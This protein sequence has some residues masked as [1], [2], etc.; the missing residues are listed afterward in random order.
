MRKRL[1]GDDVGPGV[2]EWTTPDESEEHDGADAKRSELDT[3]RKRNGPTQGNFSEYG[4]ETYGAAEYGA[5]SRV[6][7]EL[8]RDGAEARSAGTRPLRSSELRS[9]FMLPL[10][11]KET[12]RTRD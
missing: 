9:R 6:E 4:A 12:E 7:T 2:E 5:D 8:R 1:R 11:D 10:K 3:E